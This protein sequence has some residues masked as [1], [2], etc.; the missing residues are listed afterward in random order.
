MITAQQFLNEWAPISETRSEPYLGFQMFTPR[1]EIYRDLNTFDLRENRLLGPLLNASVAYGIPAFGAS[2]PALVLG[3]ELSWAFGPAGWYGSIKVSG[4]TRRRYGSYID[5]VA[6]AG[7][8]LATPLV[9]RI[10]RLVLSAQI[11]GVRASTAR[12]LY[13][14]GGDN[15]LRG[16]IINE[17]QGQ[18]R[19]LGHAE[20]RTAPLALFSQRFGA[21]LSYDVGHAAPSLAE[22]VL[23]HNVGIG[24]RWL[25]PQFNSSVMRFD[26]AIPFQNTMYSRAGFPGRFM[27]GFEQ[28]F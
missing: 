4:Q 3:G 23:H 11:E 28:V 17:F 8:Y 21:L 5:Q 12:L 16:Y 26:W 22:I 19:T 1:Y 10:A 9:A 25:I 2:F 20:I 7:A 15:G 27:A 24:L 18:V 6:S 13:V 14:L